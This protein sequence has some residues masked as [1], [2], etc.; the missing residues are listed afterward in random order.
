ML[1]NRASWHE[2]TFGLWIFVLVKQ[3][4]LSL[5]QYADDVLMM[6]MTPGGERIGSLAARC[7]VGSG[8]FTQKVRI[9]GCAG[10]QVT[11]LSLCEP[12]AHVDFREARAATKDLEAFSHAQCRC[13]YCISVHGA[14]TMGLWGRVAR[15]AHCGSDWLQV[16]GEL[17]CAQKA[18]TNETCARCSCA[19]YTRC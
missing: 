14:L 5:C 3:V 19:R 13:R 1:P 15:Q 18:L 8:D 9:S 4:D 6:A 16:Y 17:L 7:F 2:P 12:G 10:K 11:V